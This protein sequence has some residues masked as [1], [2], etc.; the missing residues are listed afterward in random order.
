M[1]TEQATTTSQ[2]FILE[3]DHGFLHSQSV[4]LDSQEVF[5]FLQNDKHLEQVLENLPGDVEN[6]LD[7]KLVHAKQ[8]ADKTYEIK[9]Q[10]KPDSKFVGHLTFF[11]SE[12]RG[13]KS[14]VITL[15]ANFD[16]INFHTDSPSLLI[17]F[18]LKRLKMLMETGEIATTKGQPHGKEEI[19]PE[20]EKVLH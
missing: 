7:L 10:N 8:M 3:R 6:F 14:S 12:T 13:K 16:K 17:T 2:N 20:N 19:K 5:H 9:W 1:N 15:E 18:F 4:L 11:L